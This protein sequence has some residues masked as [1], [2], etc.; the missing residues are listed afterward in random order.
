MQSNNQSAIPWPED[1]A[2]LEQTLLKELGGDSRIYIHRTISEGK[3]GARVMVA[4]VTSDRFTG[5]AIL[6]LDRAVG[7]RRAEALEHERHKHAIEMAPEYAEA[8][9]PK[10]VCAVRHQDEVAALTT[11]AARGLE[12]AVSWAACPY[13]P[14]L[15]TAVRLSDDL[16]ERWNAKYNLDP[17]ML[18]PQDLLNSWLDYRTDPG[19]GG[20]IHDFISA[21]CAIPPETPAFT[22]DGEWFPNPLAFALRLIQLP[23]SARLRAV[24]GNQHGDLHGK[25]VLVTKQFEADPHYYLIDLDFYRDDGFLFYDHG[26]F[27]LDYLLTSRERISPQHWKTLLGNLKRVAPKERDAGLQG[28]DIGILQLVH[29]FRDRPRQWVDRHEPNRLS[30]LESQYLLARL[31]AGLAISHQRRD[32][33][34]RAMAFLYAADNLKDYLALHE[35]EWP[36]HGPEFGLDALYR[37]DASASSATHQPQGSTSQTMPDQPDLGRPPKRAIAVLPFVG[38]PDQSERDRITDS[39]SDGIIAELSRIDWFT[40]IGRTST[41]AYRDADPDPVRVGRELNAQYLVMGTVREKGDEFQTAVRL[42]DTSSGEDVWSDRYPLKPDIEDIFTAEDKIAHTI[43]SQIDI[44]LA[45]N[46]WARALRKRP[47][48]LDSWDMFMRARWHFFQYTREDDEIARQMCLDAMK[49]APNYSA[50]YALLAQLKN[51]SVFF[52]WTE[53]SPEGFAE[54][55]QYGRKAVKLDPG[56]SFA[57]ESLTHA[58]MFSGRTNVA[59]REAETAISLNPCSGGAHQALAVALLWAGKPAEALP[60][61]DISLRLSPFGQSLVYK[62]AIKSAALLL[63]GRLQKSEELARQ[64]MDT[65]HGQVIGHVTLALTLNRQGRLEEAREAVRQASQKR[66][67]MKIGIIQKMASGMNPELKDALVKRLTILGMPE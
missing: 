60:V 38:L 20:R 9:L 30:F 66:P 26:I 7:S 57:H 4:D 28:E 13:G 25:N 31:T 1:Y 29:Q 51:R 21:N 53:G 34:S 10:L 44:E 16:L 45:Q 3:S 65:G 5:Q 11:I 2:A 12:Y 47:E 32:N 41:Q 61:I 24:R 15:D 36:K 62:L 23:E 50:P 43:A 6:K 33:L 58:Y 37:T 39:L 14:Q 35:F 55:L 64:A 63:L 46:E 22:Y 17:D 56:S 54:A 49:E 42:V 52:G 59:I 40:T 18:M 27:E 67:D 19:R 48:N 8:Y